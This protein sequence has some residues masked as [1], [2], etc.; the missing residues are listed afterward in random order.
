M[1]KQRNDARAERV[2]AC[3]DMGF[4]LSETCAA[5]GMAKVM[6]GYYAKTR[7]FTFRQGRR[8]RKKAGSR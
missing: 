6:V 1:A 7:S 8:G 2:K 5:L 3:A 4:T